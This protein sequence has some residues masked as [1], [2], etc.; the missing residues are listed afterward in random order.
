MDDSCLQRAVASIP[1][2]SIL[3]IEDIDCAFP[4]REDLEDEQ[5]A[6]MSGF[7]GMVPNLN[8]FVHSQRKSAVTLS[9][10]LNVIDGVGSEDGKLF[11]ATVRFRSLLSNLE[12]IIELLDNLS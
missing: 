7:P 11:F 1:K 3:L 12:R 10:L 6:M 9:G 5:L 4:S 8:P 2:Q